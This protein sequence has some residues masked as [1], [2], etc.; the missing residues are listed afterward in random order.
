MKDPIAMLQAICLP[1]RDLHNAVKNAM[2]FIAKK[3]PNNAKELPIDGAHV[4]ARRGR[5]VIEAT[6]TAKMIQINV[7]THPSTTIAEADNGQA[8]DQDFGI[9]TTDGLKAIELMLREA[10]KVKDEPY[11]MVDIAFDDAAVTIADDH[12]GQEQ[13]FEVITDQTYPDIDKLLT[14]F[15]SSQA[16]PKV[17]N[18]Y[19]RMQYRVLTAVN[20]T[21]AGRSQQAISV[22]FDAKRKAGC[23]HWISQGEVW[24]Q[25]L[26]M[27]LTDHG[28][29]KGIN[30]TDP[31]QF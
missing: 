21:R 29:R 27:P 22:G 10:T 19:D 30:L 25:G 12:S 14:A 3:L 16:P 24:A 5:L 20:D 23:V 13:T 15:D 26:I 7:S 11:P 17:L 9:I 2:L 1:A 6:D 18:I 8:P 4:V 31:V 28:V